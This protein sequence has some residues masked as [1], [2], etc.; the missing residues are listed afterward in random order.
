[1][2]ELAVS[3][4]LEMGATAVYCRDM[5]ND[6]L[7]LDGSWCWRAVTWLVRG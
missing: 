2:G 3:S 6:G 1:M 4:S 7:L 5:T